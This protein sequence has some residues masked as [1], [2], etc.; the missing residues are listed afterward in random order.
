MTDELEAILALP[1]PEYEDVTRAL[2]DVGLWA[3]DNLA[4]ALDRARA[5]REEE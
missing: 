2:R 3:A 4:D 5:E 1:A